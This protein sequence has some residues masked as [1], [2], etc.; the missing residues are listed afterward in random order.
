MSV[1][2]LSAFTAVPNPQMLA[3]MGAQS[4][5]MMYQAGE[6]WQYGKRRISAMSNEEFNKL[7]PQMVMEKQAV[8]LRS[9]LA[10]IERSMN[11]MTPMIGTIVKQYGDFIREIIAAIPEALQ[12][13]MGVS[14]PPGGKQALLPGVPGFITPIIPF[15]GAPGQSGGKTF[16]APITQP[17]SSPSTK[18]S[19]YSIAQLKA[20]SNVQLVDLRNQINSGAITVHSGT[21]TDIQNE[22]NLRSGTAPPA[23]TRPETSNDTKIFE[24]F[25]WKTAQFNGIIK[26]KKA[27][28]DAS[29]KPAGQTSLLQW[30]KDTIARFSKS[31]KQAKEAWYRFFQ[32][33]R[34]SSILQIKIDATRTYQSRPF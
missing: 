29:R 13:A 16:V 12:N 28:A 24:Y 9:S 15:I 21:R 10:T 27:I 30:Q 25:A 14:S 7:T 32:G 34:N 4:F 18:V 11:D 26:M 8:V 23:P 1:S 19:F 3:F 20:M 5:I 33:H 22:I 17:I 2:P 31:L 6:G